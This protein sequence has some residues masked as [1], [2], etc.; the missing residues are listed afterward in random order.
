VKGAT[1][2]DGRKQLF[3]ADAC[4]AQDTLQRA[5]SQF[6]VKWNSYREASW[7]GLIAQAYVA[8]LLSGYFVSELP[9]HTNEILLPK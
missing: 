3:G 1:E 6:F 2:S 4:F 9:Q 7:F 5:G 8:A